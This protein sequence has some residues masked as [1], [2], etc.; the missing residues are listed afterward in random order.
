MNR[1]INHVNPAD[2]TVHTSVFYRLG[3]ER[4]HGV[5]QNTFAMTDSEKLFVCSTS[6]CNM[7][8]DNYCFF[9]RKR[10]IL[11]KKKI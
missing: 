8:S 10:V 4:N 1:V 5:Q 7:V 6:D 3:F 2:I 11:K 9:H